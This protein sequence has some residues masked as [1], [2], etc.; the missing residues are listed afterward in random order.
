VK[1]G[2]ESWDVVGLFNW[3]ENWAGKEHVEEGTRTISADLA[4]L[5]LDPSAKYL[6]FDFWNEKFLGTFSGSVGVELAPRTCRVLAVRRVPAHPWFLSYNRHLTQ[7]GVELRSVKWDKER[8][9]LTGEQD[10]A[11]GYEYHIYFYAPENYTVAS[12]TAD[13]AEAAV[14]RDGEVVKLRFK[15]GATRVEWEI[16]FK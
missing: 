4:A 7:G 14:E 15:A 1:T 8:R 5:G 9:S 16:L 13:G 12:S 3:G 10:A 11:P 2:F 6:V